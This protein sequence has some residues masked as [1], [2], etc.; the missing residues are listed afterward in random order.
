[1]TESQM[2]LLVHGASGRMGRALLRLAADDSR[3]IVVAAVSRAGVAFDGL[4]VPFFAS[5]ELSGCPQF[6]VA[7]DFSLP[8]GFDRLL[9]ECLRR[10]AALVS[11]TTGLDDHQRTRISEAG[12]SIPIVWASNFSLGV[13]VM[14]DLVRRAAQALGNWHIDITETH[15]EHKKDAPSGTAL[16]LARAAQHG[17]RAVPEIRSVR[18]GEVIGEHCVRFSG[19][20]E[21]LELTHRASNRDVFSLGALEAAA[22]LPGRSAGLWRLSD[23][24]L[25]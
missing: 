10:R 25:L 9:A 21:Y 23:L 22:R 24:M 19:A 11:G 7:V 14:E 16:T 15:H 18:E 20:G 5:S 12:N 3:F 1:M 8:D 13:V 6:D 4:S 2:R 17:Q